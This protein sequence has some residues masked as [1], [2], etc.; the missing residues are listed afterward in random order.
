MWTTELL[1][2]FFSLIP[3]IFALGWG[4]QQ[5][6]FPIRTALRVLPDHNETWIINDGGFWFFE[7]KFW[8]DKL[9][10]QMPII[11]NADDL[12]FLLNRVIVNN[13]A[14]YDSSVWLGRK[15]VGDTIECADWMDGSKVE[16]EFKQL[17][18]CY[19]CSDLSCCAMSLL[20]DEK[21]YG[22]ATFGSC[23]YSKRRVC[24]LQGNIALGDKNHTPET[25]HDKIPETHSKKS[26]IL[27]IVLSTVFSC[28]VTNVVIITTALR[29]LKSFKP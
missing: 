4:S 21:N 6:I 10:G 27:A 9:G 16:Y 13:S 12:D 3:S 18:G 5:E 26:I 14:G 20:F 19:S 8:C 22:Y 28:I 24:V 29:I 1:P 23:S 7:S 25:P 2:L 15:A 17:R 11:R